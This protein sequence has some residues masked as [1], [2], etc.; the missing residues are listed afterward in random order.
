MLPDLIREW[1]WPGIGLLILI[2][3]VAVWDW[4]PR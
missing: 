1:I 2:A 4:H 3:A